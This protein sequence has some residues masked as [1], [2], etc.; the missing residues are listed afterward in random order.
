MKTGSTDYS[1]ALSLMDDAFE[2]NLHEYLYWGLE[3]LRIRP[4]KLL[5]WLEEGKL[6]NLRLLKLVQEKTS[7]YGNKAFQMAA[8]KGILK[9]DHSFECLEWLFYGSPNLK[10][11]P[12]TKSQFRHLLSPYTRS[13]IYS[14][15]S[16]AQNLLLQISLKQLPLSDWV[17]LVDQHVFEQRQDRVSASVIQNLN[18][19]ILAE[20][21]IKMRSSNQNFFGQILP[22]LHDEKL[23]D[24]W[25]Q[26]WNKL[27]DF[28]TMNDNLSK[29]IL[30]FPE[31]NLQSF[32]KVVTEK[33]LAW[34][35]STILMEVSGPY[36]KLGSWILN[37]HHPT[38]SDTAFNEYMENLLMYSRAFEND[39]FAIILQHEAL[40]KRLY[41]KHFQDIFNLARSN[42]LGAKSNYI[43]ELVTEAAQLVGI[44]R[45]DLEL[46]RHM[47]AHIN[48]STA[49]HHS[50]IIPNFHIA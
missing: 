38:I 30:I 8:Q 2:Q 10:D 12:I 4:L 11:Y 25:N 14:L 46:S 28:N 17:S 9:E 23:R 7:K 26:V 32:L 5:K 18:S 1:T 20:L 19:D 43:L 33:G 39:A 48:P 45:V 41:P 31:D 40:T 15:P 22:T 35:W 50:P 6:N 44:N 37:R 29:N 36:M 16:H 49:T 27:F 24:I 21:V 47:P 13:H 42:Q 34:D 3:R